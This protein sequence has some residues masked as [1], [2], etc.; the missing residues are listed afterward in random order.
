MGGNRAGRGGIMFGNAT[1]PGKALQAVNKKLEPISIRLGFSTWIL[2]SLR[3][4]ASSPGARHL[5]QL[6]PAGNPAYFVIMYQQ[7]ERIGKNG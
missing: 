7:R 5:K 4:D 3:C 6:S 1:S 2:T